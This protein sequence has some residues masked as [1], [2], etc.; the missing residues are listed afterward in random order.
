M[1][2]A[3][4]IAV[5]ATIATV[6]M[7]LAGAS[8]AAQPRPGHVPGVAGW[9]VVKQ[10]GKRNYAGPNCPGR[11]WNCTTAKRV[12]QIATEGGQNKAECT[13]SLGSGLAVDGS[14]QSCVIVQSSP[15]NTARCVE[16]ST[17][18]GAAQSC[19]ITQ[20]GADNKAFVDQSIEQKD[21][22]TQSGTQWAKVTQGPAAGDISSSNDL[23]L[24]QDAKQE[25][26]TGDTQ[27]QD[28]YQ[29]AV[30]S[31]TAAGGGKNESHGDQSQLQKAFGGSMQ[32]QDAGGGSPLADCASGFPFVP[33]A[34]ANVFQHSGSGK[35]E[36]HLRQFINQDA[37]S[38]GVATQSQ[39]AFSG[40][41]DGA[42]HQETDPGSS[43]SS[44]NHANQSKLQKVSA[45]AGSFQTQIDPIS[46]CNF[47]SQLGGTGNT[48]DIDQSSKLEATEPAA[49]QFVQQLGVSVHPDGDGTC[50][51]NQHATVNTDST[52]NS[53][54]FTPCPFLLL[55]TACTE[56]ECTPFPPSTTPP[57]GI[58]CIDEVFV[59]FP[60]R[61]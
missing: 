10:V 13:P 59:A 21:D 17:A 45:A 35:N 24:S 44:K 25:A 27:M 36:N 9:T 58:E 46:C 61:G 49:G 14:S 12:L 40:G 1:T 18:A 3:S 26:K 7:V 42:V 20:T 57:C 8:S 19:D 50:M 2:R 5:L 38:S 43:G 55:A 29:S 30:V 47:A 23:H 33:N 53:A 15:S 6:A 22:S 52:T 31:Q 54:S 34:C 48:E 51:V 41:L 28:V 32:S 56:G 37:N 16:R 4:Y 11:G 39:G 60:P